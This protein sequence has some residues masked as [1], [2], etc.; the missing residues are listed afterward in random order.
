MDQIIGA[1]TNGRQVHFAVE[2]RHKVG[3]KAG[4]TCWSWVLSPILLSNL[5][6][7]MRFGKKKIQIRSFLS[8]PPRFS[9]LS[10]N[11]ENYK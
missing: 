10:K 7:L 6:D 5:I 11:E 3:Y 8:Y 2:L 4:T 1:K 9:D